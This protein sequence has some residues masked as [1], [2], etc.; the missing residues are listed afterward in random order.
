MATKRKTKAKRP[1]KAKRSTKAKRPTRAKRPARIRGQTK[2]DLES[3]IAQLEAKL[4][5]LSADVSGKA[6]A[7]KAPPPPPKPEVKPETKA[8][9]PPEVKPETKAPPPPEV[10]PEVKTPPKPAEE[11][12]AP[13]AT[14][15]Q[16]LENLWQNYPMSNTHDFKAKVTGFSPNPNRYLGRRT[17]PGGTAP[18]QNWNLQKAVVTGYTA[19]SNQYFATRARMSYHPADKNFTGYG[20]QIEGA[21]AQTQSAPPP[22]PPPPPPPQ[23]Q[24]T[25]ASTGGGK[26][27]KQAELEAYEKDYMT[28]LANQEQEQAKAAETASTSQPSSKAGALPKGF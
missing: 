13:P 28:R 24:Q 21:T 4:S 25:T 9:P 14:L 1:T 2:H 3:K 5:K 8:P 20:L 16:A 12:A 17:A 11:K 26:S 27:S 18:T 10:K 23:V 7:Q 6:E 15:A 19:C 22:P